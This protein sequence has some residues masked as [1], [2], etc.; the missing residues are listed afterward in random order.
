MKEDLT[1]LKA[2]SHLVKWNP[3]NLTKRPCAISSIFLFISSFKKMNKSHF[4]IKSFLLMINI[5]QKFKQVTLISYIILLWATAHFGWSLVHSSLKVSGKE[6]ICYFVYKINHN[7]KLFTF[8]WYSATKYQS[9][10]VINKND[11]FNQNLTKLLLFI[12][13]KI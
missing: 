3:W 7:N 6:Q 5:D 12:I 10:S 11:V 4:S 9:T 1:K 13:S 8:I 2:E